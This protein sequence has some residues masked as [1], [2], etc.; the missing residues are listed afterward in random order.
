MAADDRLNFRYRSAESLYVGFHQARHELHEDE[1]ADVCGALSNKERANAF[2][3]ASPWTP[4][5]LVM[6]TPRGFEKARRGWE[7]P[8]FLLRATVDDES[9]VANA[10]MPM[11]DRP[12]SAG[13][14]APCLLNPSSVAMARWR[15]QA[16][17]EPRPEWE[18]PDRMSTW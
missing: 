1:A 8:V 7:G 16:G 2:A 13:S 11:D 18:D 17:S 14:P 10:A 9:P 4:R 3:S 5:S 12:R 15:V 6:S